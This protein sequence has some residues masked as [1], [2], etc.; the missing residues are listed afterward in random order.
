MQHRCQFKPS[1]CQC[2]TVDCSNLEST[3]A[4]SLS[5]CQFKPSTCQCRIVDD[6]HLESL[7]VGVLTVQVQVVTTGGRKHSPVPADVDGHITGCLST[8][9]PWES[10][11]HNHP[12]S[13]AN[14]L[15]HS[16]TLK[17]YTFQLSS[18]CTL[19]WPSQWVNTVTT[20]IMGGSTP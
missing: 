18:F 4:A 13:T 14:P 2:R 7:N 15:T 17:Q 1:T 19:P 5:L 12:T 20:A 11:E 6:S 10:M 16:Q 8:Q 9:L 3:D